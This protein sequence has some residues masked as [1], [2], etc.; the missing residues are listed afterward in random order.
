MRKVSLF[1]ICCALTLFFTSCTQ[2]KSKGSAEAQVDSGKLAPS[3]QTESG[4]VNTSKN[5]KLSDFK[6]KIVLLDFWTYGC[7]N[8]QHIIPDLD[9]LEKKFPN[10][11]VIIGVHSGK[12]STEKE[13][14][15]ILSAIEKFGIHHP[16]VN[17]AGF[18][19]WKEYHVNAWPTVVL[20]NP[21]GEVV[22]KYSGEGVYKVMEPYIQK[23]AKEDK[24]IIDTK[25]IAFDLKKAPKTILR[26]PS[27]M[28]KS[29]DGD[30]FISDSGHNRILLIDQEGNIKEKIGSEQ[31]KLTDGSFHSAS[32]NEPQGLSLIGNKLYVADTKDNSL[33]EVDLVNK[34]VK[35]VSGDGRL[36]YYFGNSDW[37]VNVLPNSPWGLFHKGDNIY[38]ANAGN[39]QILRFDL[40]NGEMY[41][42]AGSGAEELENGTL[43]IAGFAQPSGIAGIGNDLYIA[44]T[45][46]S[47]I[48]KID[49]DKKE[50]TTLIGMGLFVFGDRDGPFR[51]ALLQH[52]TSIK[53]HNGD[54]YIA[55]TYN[56]KIKKLDL[57]TKEVSTVVGGLNEPNDLVFVSDNLIWISNTNDHEIVTY[58]MATK[59]KK[60][61]NVKE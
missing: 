1:L 31:E 12:F 38:V 17:D 29:A 40:K 51:Q 39:H 25:P 15:K 26:F 33:R 43:K 20:I 16:V 34:V 22:G 21:K 45:E 30:V 28:I 4:W 37:G 50:V 2:D 32:F 19:V 23:L 49:L 48:R 3:I 57:K 13:N 10:E 47:A 41:R 53:A 54:L 61:L 42:F 56:G 6:G 44:D 7:I 11:L 35:T 59:E 52:V 5:W 8:C 60:V 18:K 36:G 46:A 27:K 55:D 14:A 24:S 58:N 9:K